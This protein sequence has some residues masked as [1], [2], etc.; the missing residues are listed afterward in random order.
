MIVEYPIDSIA[1]RQWSSRSTNGGST[2]VAVAGV[3]LFEGET[4][5]GYIY[6]Y[7]DGTELRPPA[8]NLAQGQIQLHFNLSQYNSTLDLLH[9]EGAVALYYASSTDAGLKTGKDPFATPTQDAV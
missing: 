5:R 8:I 6:F 2:G 4:Y 1:V 3:Y 7:P 9:N